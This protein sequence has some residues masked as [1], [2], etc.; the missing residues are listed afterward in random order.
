MTLNYEVPIS[1]PSRTA[2]WIGWI[3]SVLPVF[4][5]VMSAAMKLAKVPAAVE[6]FKKFGYPE[7]LLMVLGIVELSCAVLYLIPST[8]ALGAILVTGYLGGAVATH[9]RL[10]DPHFILPFLLGVLAWLGLFL[11]DRRVRALIPLRKT[12]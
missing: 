10:S 8:A 3:I 11:R 7:P 5:M 4:A 12:S 9:A 1:R 6:G 2:F